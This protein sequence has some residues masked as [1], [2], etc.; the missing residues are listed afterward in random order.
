MDQ[1]L[2]NNFSEYKKFNDIMLN[3]VRYA[4]FSKSNR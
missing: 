1:V 3:Q 4:K 2:D